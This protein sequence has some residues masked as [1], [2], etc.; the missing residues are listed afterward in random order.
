V[1]TT[2]AVQ[3]GLMSLFMASCAWGQTTGAVGGLNI[4]VTDPQNGPLAGAEVRYQRIYRTVAGSGTRL[5][6]AAGETLVQATALVDAN[7][8]LVAPGLAIGDYLLCARVPSAAYLDPCIWEGG[9]KVTVSTSAVS[10]QSIVLPKGVFLK[11]RANDPLGLL[12]KVKS[13]PLGGGRLLVGVHYANGAYV[14]AENTAVDSSR[15]D[16]QM[17]IPIGIPLKLWLFSSH[18]T[19]TDASGKAVDTSG[20]SIPFQAAAGQDQ[21]FTFTVS[22]ATAQ[23]Q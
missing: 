4:T 10:K 23:S 15:R 14:G 3:F 18:V 16:Y 12:P 9:L 8:A 2:K 11:V 7:G 13:G 17:A 6:P 20:A 22:G 21:I 19:L 5:I 1:K